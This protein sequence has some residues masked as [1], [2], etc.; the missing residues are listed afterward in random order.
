[1]R[2]YKAAIILPSIV[3]LLSTFPVVGYSATLNKVYE[4]KNG[5][6]TRNDLA[7]DNVPFPFRYV[8]IYKV[9]WEGAYDL[10][11]LDNNGGLIHHFNPEKRDGLAFFP[12]STGR[13]ILAREGP[14]NFDPPNMEP[15]IKKV[16]SNDGELI[17]SDR[18]PGYPRL[19]TDGDALVIF[20]TGQKPP[21]QVKAK[22]KYDPVRIVDLKTGVTTRIDWAVS[23]THGVSESA[24]TGLIALPEFI[25]YWEGEKGGTRIY[26][27]NGNLKFILDPGFL[28]EGAGVNVRGKVLHLSDNYIIQAGY[29]IQERRKVVTEYRGENLT[30]Y[31][32][33][34]G[35]DCDNGI[36]V[37]NGRG[38]LLWEE[39][40]G[41][42]QGDL[43]IVV[44]LNDEYV[45][46]RAPGVLGFR[47]YALSDRN[48]KWRYN[49]GFD[50]W[51]S[52]GALSDDGKMLVVSAFD[53]QNRT[54]L[55]YVVEE[56]RL[57]EC[58]KVPSKDN[59]RAK[60]FVDRSG[61]YVL[62]TNHEGGILYDIKGDQ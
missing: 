14:F 10:Y 7:R 44:S 2:K 1:M 34:C 11:T 48:E 39:Y 55:I 56:G 6:I 32:A 26:D 24:G 50:G 22:P 45:A 5:I 28:C 57:R 61:A 41:K 21:P 4:L 18:Y 40:L 15:W 25:A 35:A 51:Y 19:A 46:V 30:C 54:S 20:N 47:V 29:R 38:S 42:G 59:Y 9:D 23:E 58:I 62:I 31:G 49:S 33:E 53:Y 43:Q 16:Y 27:L 36:Q 17:W 12:S 60:G 3:F 52:T 8:P 13:V 37:Y